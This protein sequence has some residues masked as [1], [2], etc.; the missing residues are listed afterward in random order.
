MLKDDSEIIAV[1]SPKKTRKKGYRRPVVEYKHEKTNFC[2]IQ[3]CS[4]SYTTKKALNLHIRKYHK[5]S[6]QHKDASD[7]INLQKTNPITF[8]KNFNTKRIELSKIFK[9]ETLTKRLSSINKMIESNK[10]SVVKIQIPNKSIK[11]GKDYSSSGNFLTDDE[12]TKRIRGNRFP[13]EFV[14]NENKLRSQK[15]DRSKSTGRDYRNATKESGFSENL[16][17]YTLPNR[18]RERKR[19]SRKISHMINV[20]EQSLEESYWMPKSSTKYDSLL[21]KRSQI[22]KNL[23]NIKNT[24]F[25][26][27]LEIYLSENSIEK[28]SKGSYIS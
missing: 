13:K 6:D 17:L 8:L 11:K 3:N 1:D 25:H 22:K 20:D 28:Q 14:I 27:E 19:P 23:G 7:Y 2:Y 26:N 10:E 16:G 21:V 15:I 12:L 24:K 18:L 4:K 5:S 9:E